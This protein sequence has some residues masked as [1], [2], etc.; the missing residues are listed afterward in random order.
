[1]ASLIFIIMTFVATSSPAIH[2][3]TRLEEILVLLH[4][5]CRWIAIVSEHRVLLLDMRTRALR[6]L[7]PRGLEKPITDACALYFSGGNTPFLLGP[8]CEWRARVLSS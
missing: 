7:T 2:Q 4:P 5:R 6:D 3:E 1:M 8:L